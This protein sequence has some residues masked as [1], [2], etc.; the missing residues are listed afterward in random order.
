MPNDLLKEELIKRNW[1][2]QNV[3]RDDT[4]LGGTLVVPFRGASPSSISFGSLTDSSDVAAGIYVR[5]SVS[6]YK[7][8]WGT[9]QFY[10]TDLMQHGKLSEQNFLKQLPD[11][12]DDFIEYTKEALSVS[13]LGAGYFAS[14][15]QG[16]NSDGSAGTGSNSGDGQADG[17][18]SVDHPER[19]VIDQ[20]LTVDDDDTAQGDYYVIGVN[21]STSV[22]TLSATRQGGAAN[23]SSFSLAQNT[24]FYHPGVYVA[25]TLTNNFTSL[26]SSLLSS[27]NGGSSTLY[28]QTKTAYPLTIH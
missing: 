23:L 24:R 12:I 15:K 21:M 13:C 9:M 17:T 14:S 25:G 6:S 8:I 27:A 11:T 10:E 4:W 7:E 16:T 18:I 20:K 22:I 19:F 26:R 5:G 1:L 28:G 2:L 3:E